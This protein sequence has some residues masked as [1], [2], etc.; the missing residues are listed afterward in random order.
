M[1]VA[2]QPKIV[3]PSLLSKTDS[4]TS[5]STPNH[6][7]TAL[8]TSLL[9]PSL[10]FS[11]PLAPANANANANAATTETRQGVYREYSVDVSAPQTV[12]NADS[13]FKDKATTKSNKGKYTALL[14]VLVMGS[15]VIPMG[16]YFWYVKEDDSFDQY[17]D[18]KLKK[19]PA[20]QVQ[21]KKGFTF[22]KKAE[23]LPP[24]PPPKKKN[25]WE[26]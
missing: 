3:S 1:T 18:S 13:Y 7:K 4:A 22:G 12:D 19:A 14:A 16:Q 21:K 24:P 17:V 10:I 8:L 25:F 23:P 26:K 6:F 15:F 11:S 5:V 2:F 20:S 9:L